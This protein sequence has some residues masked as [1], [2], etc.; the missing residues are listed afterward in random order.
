VK[1]DEKTRVDLPFI[2]PVD[3]EG[4]LNSE[5][6]TLALPYIVL[7]INNNVSLC[8][9]STPDVSQTNVDPGVGARLVQ[10]SCDQLRIN[11]SLRDNGGTSTD[12]IVCSPCMS[13]DVI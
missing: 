12:V 1:C 8:K 6:A 10:L 2:S 4:F 5:V 3:S 13:N 9:R 7:K 11:A